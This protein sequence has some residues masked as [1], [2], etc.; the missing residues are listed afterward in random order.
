MELQFTITPAHTAV[1]L[2]AAL[3]RE[4]AQLQGQQRRAVAHVAHWQSRWLS[5]L[6][7]WLCLGAGVLA[8]ARPGRALSATTYTAMLLFVLLFTWLWRRYARPLLDS[9]RARQTGRQPPLQALHERLT[10]RMLQA[11]LRREEGRWRLLL[12]AQGFTLVH[13]GRNPPRQARTA[14]A[15]IVRLQAT[16][17]FYCLATAALAA[18]GKAYHLPR[19]SDAMDPALY[20][21]E[22]AL[23]LQRCPVAL[24]P[25]AMPDASTTPDEDT[26]LALIP[27]TASSAPDR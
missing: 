12:D 5:P 9:I 6:L 22:L 4:I 14:W 2:E 13:A 11:A 8:I 7:Y 27:P 19:H 10:R 26:A 17:V 15:D 18:Q 1:R 20:Q 23:W 3:Q 25:R 24:E 21:R 16:P